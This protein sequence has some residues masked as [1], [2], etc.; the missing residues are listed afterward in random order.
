MKRAWKWIKRAVIG[1]AVLMLVA[2]AVVGANWKRLLIAWHKRQIIDCRAA[3][4][5]DSPPLMLVHLSSRV[6]GFPPESYLAKSAGE[7][8]LFHFD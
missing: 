3:M 1:V 2:A 6:L 5:D 7:R 8:I 4:D